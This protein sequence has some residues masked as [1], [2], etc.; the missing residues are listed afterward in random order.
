MT[1]H[2]ARARDLLSQMTLEEKAGQVRQYFCFGEAAHRSEQ[3]ASRRE[4]LKVGQFPPVDPREQ[5]RAGLE[6]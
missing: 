4:R 1:N 6:H 2:K 5:S 3:R